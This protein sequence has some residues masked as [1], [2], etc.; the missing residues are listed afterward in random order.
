MRDKKHH[1]IDSLIMPIIS[2]VIQE[3]EERIL[4]TVFYYKIL[5]QFCSAHVKKHF[6]NYVMSSMSFNNST[7]QHKY[8]VQHHE[9][10]CT[11]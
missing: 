4:N 5:F 1:Y 11:P 3:I 6:N 2:Y 10:H 8:R 7:K 9:F